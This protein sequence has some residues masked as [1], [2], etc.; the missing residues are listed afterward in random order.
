MLDTVSK[1]FCIH[2]VIKV[3][4]RDDETL[5]SIIRSISLITFLFTDLIMAYSL[6]LQQLICESFRTL[7]EDSW[8]QKIKIPLQDRI[9]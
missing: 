3:I 2:K 9:F 7:L 6:E 1:T 8:S 5:F 4:L